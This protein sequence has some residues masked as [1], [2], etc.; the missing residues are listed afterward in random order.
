[1]VPHIGG[2]GGHAHIAVHCRCSGAASVPMDGKG[3]PDPF[4]QCG[5]G[6]E[7]GL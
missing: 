5:P 2:K 4:K 3:M 6:G 1:M 7:W